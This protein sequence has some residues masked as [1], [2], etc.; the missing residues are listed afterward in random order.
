MGMIIFIICSSI[1]IGC[2]LATLIVGCA[3]RSSNKMGDSKGE[4][5]DFTQTN[6]HIIRNERASMF[7]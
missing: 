1:F 5:M 7:N 2:S 3:L 4:F 6:M